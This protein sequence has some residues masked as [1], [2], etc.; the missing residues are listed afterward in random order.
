MLI[1]IF[2]SENLIIRNYAQAVRML[3][4]SLCLQNHFDNFLVTG[5]SSGIFAPITPSVACDGIDSV[6]K[7]SRHYLYP[8]NYGR[9]PVPT[10]RTFDRIAAGNNRSGFP[11]NS[12]IG[13]SPEYALRHRVAGARPKRL[14]QNCTRKALPAFFVK[15]CRR[16]S[17]SV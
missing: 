2:A 5:S 10:K 11:C 3:F 4:N 12:V 8:S 6:T 1:Y 13:K 7:R 17:D 9:F 16:S 15:F 14:E